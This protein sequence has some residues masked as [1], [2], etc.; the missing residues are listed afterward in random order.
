MA[1]MITDECINC[2]VCEPE[3]P[4]DAIDGPGNLCD[5]PE[6]VHGVRRPFRRAAVHSGVSR[7]VHSARSRASGN[8]GRLDGEVSRVTGGKERVRLWSMESQNGEARA[9]P[10]FL[11][12]P[13]QL[14]S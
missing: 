3:C 11:L 10:F 12:R 9:S 1:L 14:I 8:A 6:K 2:D 7:R 13:D 4:N 5:R